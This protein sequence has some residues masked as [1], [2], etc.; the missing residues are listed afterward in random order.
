MSSGGTQSLPWGGD[1]TGVGCALASMA[2]HATNTAA[3]QRRA[4][5]ITPR[6]AQ[7]LARERNT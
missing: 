1:A 4:G 5:A 7:D 3:S 6:N 2:A